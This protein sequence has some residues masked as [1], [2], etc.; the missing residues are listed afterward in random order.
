MHGSTEGADGR[1]MRARWIEAWDGPLLAGERP[2]PRPDGGEVLIEVEACGVGLTVLNAIR[3]DLGQEPGNLP[4]IPGHE[5][6]GRVVA[7]G[8]GVGE[9]LVGRRAMAYFYLVCGRCRRCVAGQESL[10]EQLGGF[11]GVDRDGGYAERVTLPARNAI[12]LD[13]AIDPVL[14]TTIPDAIA[15]PVHV[16]ARAAIGVED[17][18]AVIAA[19]GGVGAHMAQVAR[20]F[21]ARA[22]VGLEA[23]RAK[24]D[25]LVGELE[26]DAVDSSDFEAVRLPAAFAGGADVVVDLLGTRASMAWSL[27][28][29]RTGGRLVVLTT[30]PGV[31]TEVLPR[32]LVFRQLS[33]VGSRYAGRA[34]LI[35]AAE[36]VRERRVEP[37]VSRTVGPDGLDELHDLLRA[38]GLVGRGAL[39][40]RRA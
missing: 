1:A 10:C 20:A 14:A 7:V 15:T 19:A 28:S 17:T 13:E 35:R 37:I 31:G 12:L 16:A 38:G 27:R 6:V 36:L 2:Q 21:G 30:F 11:V 39:D 3:G 25:W 33:I 24:L 8:A 34:E 26:I 29:L 18:V 23:T 32:D 40:W 9:G 22:V 5:L 4:R